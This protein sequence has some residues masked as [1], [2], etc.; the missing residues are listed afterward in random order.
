MSTECNVYITDLHYTMPENT[1]ILDVLLVEISHCIMVPSVLFRAGGGLCI[2]WSWTSQGCLSDVQC[3]HIAYFSLSGLTVVSPTAWQ[4]IWHTPYLL[5][6]SSHHKTLNTH[7]LNIHSDRDLA[8]YSSYTLSRSCI[9]LCPLATWKFIQ[10]PIA[11][12][13]IHQ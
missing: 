8:L 12:S 13:F 1:F 10:E 11:L 9:V 6:C 7:H 5:L 2:M 4:V 3:H